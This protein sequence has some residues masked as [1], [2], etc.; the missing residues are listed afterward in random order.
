[1]DRGEK[2]AVGVSAGLLPSVEVNTAHYVSGLSFSHQ[3]SR[4]A[5]FVW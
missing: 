1:M 5:M 3:V 4:L 2:V